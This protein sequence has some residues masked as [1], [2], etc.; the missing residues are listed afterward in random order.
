VKYYLIKDEDIEVL[1]ALII[2]DPRRAHGRPMTVVET[3]AHDTAH[4]FYNYQVEA[5]IGKITK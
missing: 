3:E 4:R 2:Q 1:R 5:W